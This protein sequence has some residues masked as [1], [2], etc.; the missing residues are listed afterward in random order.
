MVYIEQ[1]GGYFRLNSNQRI[2]RVER[3]YRVTWPDG[4]T[5]IGVDY[6]CRNIGTSKTGDFFRVKPDGDECQRCLKALY[7]PNPTV[8]HGTERR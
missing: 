8:T 5:W 6:W 1:P 3:A 7:G 4:E 2:H